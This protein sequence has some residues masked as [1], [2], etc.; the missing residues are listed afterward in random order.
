MSAD[1]RCLIIPPVRS[2]DHNPI[3]PVTTP[4]ISLGASVRCGAQRDDADRQFGVDHRWLDAMRECAVR[5]TR[6]TNDGRGGSKFEEVEVP[7][8]TTPYAT[9]LPPLRVSAAT[10]VTGGVVFVTTPPEVRDTQS[11]P[12][13]RRQF[14]VILEGA[15]EVETT[16][17]DKW[18]FTPGM[19]A[20]V[21]DVDGQGHVT[22]IVSPAPATLMAV[23][24]AD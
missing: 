24:I 14:V 12:P 8:A 3:S 11:H 5:Y 19:V 13:P 17:G 18:T 4:D 7:Q 2:S 16:D 20:L 15:F 21:D 1:L 10:P 9:N 6:I 23:P 22:R